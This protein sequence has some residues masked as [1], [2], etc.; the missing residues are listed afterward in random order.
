LMIWVSLAFCSA[1]K[2]LV[3]IEILLCQEI[4]Q[5]MYKIVK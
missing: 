4:L 1:L 2:V 3:S 5:Q